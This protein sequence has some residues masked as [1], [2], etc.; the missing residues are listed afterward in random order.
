MTTPSYKEIIDEIGTILAKPF[1]E[2]PA[3]G[4]GEFCHFISSIAIFFNACTGII[5]TLFK[6][7][8]H[9]L[10]PHI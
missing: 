10:K 5:F 8:C 6:K 2:S 4:R 1:A 7:S 3:V 9:N